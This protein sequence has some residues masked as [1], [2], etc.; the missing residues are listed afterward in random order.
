[1]FGELF[2]D[3]HPM[4]L[5]LGLGASGLAMAR[6]CAR[7]GCRLRRADSRETPPN[8][9]LLEAE[10]IEAELEMLARLLGRLREPPAKD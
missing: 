1:M 8:L 2:R 7:H 6:W 3:R 5:V 9:A 10:R 4:V